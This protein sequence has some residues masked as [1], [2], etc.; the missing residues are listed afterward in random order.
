M[1]ASLLLPQL[2]VLTAV[3]G[4]GAYWWFILVPSARVRLAV[5]KKSGKLREYLED[6]K[7][8]D[9]RPLERWFY[10]NWLEKVDPETKYLLREDGSSEQRGGD[11]SMTSTRAA[12]AVKLD[13][14]GGVD[15]GKDG[16]DTL[17]EVIR[18]AKKTP[19]FWSADNPVLVGMTISILGAMLFGGL[20]GNL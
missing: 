8:D 11:G 15:T 19:K 4:A 12:T 13:E 14:T 16:D 17:E 6:L 18:K 10:A 9:S 2:A 3:A 20:T 5:N 1:D 7:E